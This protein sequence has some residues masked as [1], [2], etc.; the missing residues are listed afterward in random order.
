MLK[1]K[2]VLNDAFMTTEEKDPGNPPLGNVWHTSHSKHTL[3]PTS[4]HAAAV[5]KNKK[6]ATAGRNAGVLR[7]PGFRGNEKHVKKKK[8]STFVRKGTLQMQV[9]AHAA[10]NLVVFRGFFKETSAAS[11]LREM[12]RVSFARFPLCSSTLTFKRLGAQKEAGRA[13]HL[14]N[15]PQQLRSAEALL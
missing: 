15:V 14:S 2:S 6:T 4:A 13:S 12:F 10:V 8:K 11:T 9:I 1:S 7:L 5:K 3:E